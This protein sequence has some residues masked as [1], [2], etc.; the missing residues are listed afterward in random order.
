MESLVNKKFVL[1]IF[2][3]NCEKQIVRVLAELDD[4]LLSRI[5]QVLIIDN[6]SQDG[7]YD[8]SVKS[9]AAAKSPHKF[10]LIRNTTNLGL[11]GSHKLA[12]Q[13]ALELNADYLA[14]LHGD[15]Q[16]RVQ[17]LHHLLNMALARP[18]L[19]AVLGSRFMMKSKRRGYSLLRT[20]G[21]MGLNVIYTLLTGKITKDLG[22][23]LNV[24]SVSISDQ[25]YKYS[26]GFTF[27]MDLL[28]DLYA[29]NEKVLFVPISWFEE[30]QI[31]NA[32]TFQVGWTALK[33]IIKWRLSRF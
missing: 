33:T 29:K 16:A 5:D 8:V 22:S 9:V 28:L 11:G 10:T 1:A 12:F 17:E 25:T 14:V 20:L 15:H 30:D 3:Y 2:V 27:N 13:K 6:Q 24:F 32:K 18:D 26:S 21:N 31:S 7:S 19:K 4:K 23:G